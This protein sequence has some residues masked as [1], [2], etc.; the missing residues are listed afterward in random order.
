MTK[1]RMTLYTDDH[2]HNNFALQYLL[3][4]FEVNRIELS[5]GQTCEKI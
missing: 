3:H 4:I 1:R 2:L 5:D